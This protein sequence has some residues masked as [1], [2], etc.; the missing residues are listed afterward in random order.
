MTKTH[1]DIARCVVTLELPMYCHWDFDTAAEAR[2]YADRRV[3]QITV[4]HSGLRYSVLNAHCRC[5][6]RFET[7]ARFRT[8][9]LVK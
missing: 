9:A 6:K 1:P 3:Q 8:K 5:G 2:K 7:A 4:T